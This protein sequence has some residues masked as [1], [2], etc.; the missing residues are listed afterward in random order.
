MKHN[1]NHDQQAVKGNPINN[2]L[3]VIW[4]IAWFLLKVL[5]WIDKLNQFFDGGEN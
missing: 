4:K 1:S 2:W 3:K 5:M